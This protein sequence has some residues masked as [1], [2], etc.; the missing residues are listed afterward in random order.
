MRT[1][2][3]P[4][5]WLHESALAGSPSALSSDTR[6]FKSH[7]QTACFG[8]GTRLG[9]PGRPLRQALARQNIS[10]PLH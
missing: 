9:E 5:A 1:P 7:K 10:I 2:S 4:R 8:R 6:A 3:S